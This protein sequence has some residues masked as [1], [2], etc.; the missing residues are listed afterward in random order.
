MT[1]VHA[2]ENSCDI[3]VTELTLQAVSASI[4]CPETLYV[5]FVFAFGSGLQA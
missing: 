3:A 5:T 1:F 4:W 2:F